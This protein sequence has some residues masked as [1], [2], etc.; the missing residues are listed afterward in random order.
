MGVTFRPLTV[1]IRGRSVS[2]DISPD[3]IY[4]SYELGRPVRAVAEVTI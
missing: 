4:H 1:R 2:L 3:L